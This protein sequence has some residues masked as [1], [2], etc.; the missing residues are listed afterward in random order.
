M[1]TLWS[2][3]NQPEHTLKI[4]NTTY[5]LKGF[6]IAACRTSFYIPELKMMFDAALAANFAPENILITHCHSDHT[7][8]IPFLLYSAKD[9]RKITIYSPAESYEKINTFI[10]AAAA[11]TMDVDLNALPS[12]FGSSTSSSS[13]SSDSSPSPRNG[14]SSTSTPR[15]SSSADIHEVDEVLHSVYDMIPCYSGS[16]TEIYVHHKSICMT[17]E[18]FRCYHS[19]PS[20]GYGLV[21]K[22]TKL[23]HEYQGKSGHE[24][25]DMKH[26]GIEIDEEIEVPFFLYLGDTTIEVLQDKENEKEIWKYS[27]VMIECTFLLDEEEGQAESRK[28][29]HWNHLLPYIEEHPETFFILYHF[30]RR[31][32]AE[33][34]REFFDQNAS[35]LSNV[36]PWISS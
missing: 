26:Q 20:L 8:N 36:H 17:L 14:D 21:E 25:A 3:W 18:V 1:D 22:R 16:K 23:K 13:S 4:P 19:V 7:A 30:S 29:M 10:R 15:S 28:H 24:L 31:Y 34:I 5:T 6:S 27:T 12:S 11:M 2:V 32:K 33:E 9:G 35:S